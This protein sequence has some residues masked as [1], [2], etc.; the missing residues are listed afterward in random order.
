MKPLQSELHDYPLMGDKNYARK[1]V[2]SC[3]RAAVSRTPYRVL[4]VGRGVMVS[5]R[6]ELNWY[7]AP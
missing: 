1:T 6:C 3:V 4:E 5:A 7:D 2:E